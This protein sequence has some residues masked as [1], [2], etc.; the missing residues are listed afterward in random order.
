MLLIYSSFS[1]IIPAEPVTSR[2]VLAV[3]VVKAPVLAV[4]APIVVLSIAPAFISTVERVVE[5][6][7]YLERPELEKFLKRMVTSDAENKRFQIFDTRYF[8]ILKFLKHFKFAPERI[9][10][11]NS[12][13]DLVFNKSQRFADL[14]REKNQDLIITFYCIIF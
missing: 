7:N 14:V 8:E 10:L 2:L 5:Y 9:T 11:K 1:K 3:I 6:R 13:K 12:D 4:V